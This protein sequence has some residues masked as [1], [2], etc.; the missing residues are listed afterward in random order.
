MARL[1]FGVG[2]NDADYVVAR[3]EKVGGKSVQVWICP[4]Y[5]VWRSMLQRCF[6]L[7]DKKKHPCYE[8]ATVCVEWIYFSNFRAW[9][10]KQNWEGLY[11]DKDILSSEGTKHYSPETCAFVPREV[12]NMFLI[13][14]PK[15]GEFPLGVCFYKSY[16][17]YRAQINQGFGKGPKHL[18]YFNTPTEAHRAW[19]K[20]KVTVLRE[21][22]LWY[23][24]HQALNPG[25]L[26]ACQEKISVLEFDYETFKET[27]TI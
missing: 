26:E 10:V 25:I 18:G 23:S 27:Y 12:N 6:S 21:I 7:K 5:E 19:Q 22:L 8:T 2:V 3:N 4:F 15:R 1:V 14:A 11:L 16:G 9:M 24:E 20:A 13:N 17:N